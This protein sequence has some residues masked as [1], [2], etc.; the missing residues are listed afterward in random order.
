M[1]VA[2]YLALC[3]VANGIYDEHSGHEIAMPLAID[4]G[5]TAHYVSLLTIKVI[6]IDI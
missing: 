4:D 2:L 3:V 5:H 6:Y 1:R